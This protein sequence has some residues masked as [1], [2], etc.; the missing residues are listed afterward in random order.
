MKKSILS[1]LLVLTMVVST[2]AALP[3]TTSAETT[4]PGG[5]LLYESFEG[6]ASGNLTPQ[7]AGTTI[8]TNGRTEGNDS[9]AGLG[10][11]GKQDNAKGKHF[12]AT[13]PASYLKDADATLIAAQG[14][15][16]KLTLE[17]D[18]KYEG[19]VPTTGSTLAAVLFGNDSLAGND[20]SIGRANSAVAVY[21]Q[22]PNLITVYY[23]AGSK[24]E[25]YLPEGISFDEWHRYQLTVN[26]TNASSAGVK[27]YAITVDG[28][29]IL[30][31]TSKEITSLT[32]QLSATEIT[33]LRIDTPNQH[34]TGLDNVSVYKTTD[35]YAS[36]S[37]GALMLKLN[38]VNAKMAGYSTAAA[39]TSQLEALESAVSAAGTMVTTA[40]GT[41][42]ATTGA[43]VTPAK[44]QAEVDTVLANLTAAQEALEAYLAS[45]TYPGGLYFY[46]PWNT[47]PAEQPVA[48]SAIASHDIEDYIDDTEVNHRQKI[49]TKETLTGGNN[50]ILTITDKKYSTVQIN[51]PE[52]LNGRTPDAFTTEG[53]NADLIVEFDLNVDPGNLAAVERPIS[54]LVGDKDF[55]YNTSYTMGDGSSNARRASAAYLSTKVTEDGNLTCYTN[56]E[57][58]TTATEIGS[59][60][61]NEWHRY[62]MVFHLTDSNKALT[63]W[64]LYVDGTAIQEN[65]EI[66]K[67]PS[68]DCIKLIAMGTTDGGYSCNIDNLSVYKK[69]SENQMFS[70]ESLAIAINRVF[71]NKSNYETAGE[72]SQQLDDLNTA[73]D[74]AVTALST[75]YTAAQENEVEAQDAVN[76]VLRS[77][78]DAEAA[79]KAVLPYYV[80]SGH[81]IDDESG[82]IT[83]VTVEEIKAYTGSPVK[84]IVATYDTDGLSEV[85]MMD[86]TG[87]D[88][89]ELTPKLSVTDKEVAVFVW[90]MNDLEPLANTY[91]FGEAVEQD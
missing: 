55:V 22:S 87:A 66:C 13:L 67:A 29:Y 8:T 63:T 54:I 50:T 88:E 49:V 79:L 30:D 52:S 21:L 11:Y 82:C 23:K 53:P 2:F 38:E 35:T 80:I 73:Y 20:K 1:L 62:K 41:Y 74:A 76:E 10:Y 78:E 31:D 43:A 15:N 5:T 17:F 40:F 37:T 3:M 91:Y 19:V 70:T 68:I 47:T 34:T 28:E 64:S 90:E 36:L 12:N 26:L 4:Y 18:F 42:D 56:A 39:G 24:T 57:D 75:S 25:Y 72:G 81:T 44:T 48:D 33:K 6:I 58:S 7:P 59:V 14:P 84:L 51:L 60:S 16:A 32:S 86:F 69:N 83:A 45:L 89:Y 71:A 85:T 46:E 65:A 61:A 27:T 77:L 9:G